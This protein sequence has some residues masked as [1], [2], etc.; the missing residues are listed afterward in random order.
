MTTFN[1]VTI[2]KAA[3]ETGYTVQAIKAK[4]RDGV[5]RENYEWVKARDGRI[6]ISIEGYNLWA[7]PTPASH[8]LPIRRL[9]S[10]SPIGTNAA[11]RARSAD[12]PETLHLFTG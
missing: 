4:I 6:L 11:A 7:N 9:K 10:P 5:W 2:A 12:C 8:P 1:Y 3:F